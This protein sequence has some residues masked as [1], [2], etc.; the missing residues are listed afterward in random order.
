MVANGAGAAHAAR[1]V[2]VAVPECRPQVIVSMGFCGALDQALNIGDI[3]VA[4]SIGTQ[5]LP[6]TRISSGTSHTTGVLASID[7][8]AQTI[9][10]KE[11]LRTSGAGA[12]EMEAAG[13]AARAAAHAIPFFC[14]K[15]VTDRE[16][17]EFLTDFNGALLSDG[18]FGTIRILASALRN[19]GRVFPELFRLHRS[20]RIATR[21]LGEF[22]AGCR[23]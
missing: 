16:D 8:V 20:C 2:D 13:V 15:S 17:Q 1:A 19:P 14:I 10:E 7:H 18:H 12:V 11:S 21:K 5:P 22:I 4:T 9:A 23:F 3:F 6:A